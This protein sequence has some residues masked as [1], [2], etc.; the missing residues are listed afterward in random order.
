MPFIPLD[1]ITGALS[2]LFTLLILSYLIGDN[3]LFK[4]AVYLF[5][6][7]ASG[8]AAAVIIWQVL[9]P[10]LFMPLGNVLLTGAYGQG[11][12]LVLQ[13]SGL[14]YEWENGSNRSTIKRFFGKK[15]KINRSSVTQT[16]GNG[17][18]TIQSK[19]KFCGGLEFR[20]E[21]LLR[22]G[23]NFHARR[24]NTGHANLREGKGGTSSMLASPSR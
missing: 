16:Q 22:R 14:G 4:I 6:G 3:P 18:A 10:K 17:C 12:L 19:A 24:E 23:K 15:I 1:F 5:V 9:Y 2:F 8:Y 21:T 13:N 7:V 20:P 11:V